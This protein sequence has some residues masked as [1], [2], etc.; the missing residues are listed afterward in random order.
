MAQGVLAEVY[1]LA[2]FFLAYQPDSA[3]LWRV[4]ERG[5]VAAQ[6]S[7]DPHAIAVSAWLLAEAHRDSGQHHL[8]A[9]DHLT[10]ETLRYL[11]PLLPDA[12]DDV[13]AMSGALRAAAGYRPPGRCGTRAPD[14]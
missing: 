13:L 3:M 12:G 6:E 1:C 9:A 8:D 5:M 11:D 14:R 2:Q 7:E 10:T 4:A